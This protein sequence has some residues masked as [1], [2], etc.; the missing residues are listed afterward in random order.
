[1]HCRRGHLTH[2]IRVCM[3]VSL[4]KTVNITVP[5]TTMATKDASSSWS[6]RGHSLYAKVYLEI[7]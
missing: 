4:K 2:F 5:L 3:T 6:C 1:M 7:D